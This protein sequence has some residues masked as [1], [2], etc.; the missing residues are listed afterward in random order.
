MP[1]GERTSRP[2]NPD[3]AITA[4]R[5]SRRSGGSSAVIAANLRLPTRPLG[6][7][8]ATVLLVCAAWCGSALS[9]PPAT[10]QIITEDLPLT[11]ETISEMDL[12]LR[13]RFTR[14]WRQEDGTLTLLFNG[15]FGLDM[16]RRQLSAD[17]AVVW[18]QPRRSDPDGRKYYEL[19]IYLSERAK[20]VEAS[21]TVVEDDVLLVSNIRTFG[22][23]I[24]LDDANSPE[25][26]ENSSLYQRAVLD[27][28]R[29]QAGQEPLPALPPV[30][31]PY[32]APL[33][34]R[35]EAARPVRYSLPGIETAATPDGER[36]YVSVGRVYFS[37]SGG[38]DAPLLEIQADAAVVFPK[39]PTSQ[40]AG[41]AEDAGAAT[42][43]PAAAGAASPSAERTR[44]ERGGFTTGIDQDLRGVYLEGDVVLSF[45]NRFVRAERLYYDFEADRALILDA[46]MRVEIPERNIP[47]Y[48]RAAEIRQLSAREYSGQK[49]RLTTSEFYSPHYHIGAEK[50]I[51]RDTTLRDAAGGAA[52]PVTGEY[53]LRD[54]TFNVQGLPLAYWPYLKGRYEQTE[55]MLRSFRT[56]YSD[57]RGVYVETVFKLFEALG[58]APP[59]GWDGTL[60]LDYYS[61]RGPAIG[62]D[63]DYETENYFGLLRTYYVHDQGEDNLGPYRDN[64]PSTEHRGRVLWRHRHY[65]PNDWEITLETAFV[66]DPGFLE[67]WERSEYF[68]GKDQETAVYLKRARDTEAITLLANWRTL[69]FETQTE[70][71]PDLTYRRIGDILGPV[72]SY[73][74]ARVGTVR[75]RPDDRRFIDDGRRDNTNPTDVTFRTGGRQEF[76]LPLKL[77]AFNV[78]PF[79]TA[80]GD[81]WDGEPLDA[82]TKWRGMGTYGLRSASTWA[83]VYDS[84]Q[85]DILDINRIRHIIKPELLAW[86]SHSNT[87]P[88]LLT[89]FDEGIETVADFY[90]A[91][92]ALKQT[93]QT[94]RGAPG[95]RRTVD[96]LTLNLELGLFGEQQAGELSNGYANFIRPEDGRSRNYAAGEMIYRLSDTTSVLYDFNLD[97]NDRDLDRHNISVAVERLPRLAYIFGFRQAD[98][99]DMSLVGGGFNYRISEKHILTSR[100]WWDLKEGELGEIALGYVR[101]LPRWYVGINIEVDRVFEDFKLTFSLWPEGVP[102]WTLGSRR[103]TGLDTSTGIRPK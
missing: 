33:P 12:E 70:H 86:L 32:R 63:L 27:R 100:A 93:W 91:L 9:V 56:G 34:E 71:L 35:P 79:A 99:A 38:P 76:E 45:G 4:R 43:Q 80:R 74:E 87:R 46:V 22:R 75:Y 24:K 53:E 41:A 25:A 3:L 61:E 77:G 52:A 97:L 17:N 94:Q 44:D 92:L 68:E 23:I 65:L 48:L 81:Y 31:A 18:I 72:V 60:K 29:V 21:G 39:Q 28:E 19:T 8:L 101:K 103:F 26:I 88:E 30:A 55:T 42:T 14:Q 69:E 1:N 82:S 50:I 66:S 96:L 57:D 58:V 47:L 2:A 5:R 6:S 67:E 62:I 84:I 40:P 13:G 10:A 15:G 54:A 83:R 51:L 95:N 11:P 20:I 73:S 98:A 36:V 89:P 7:T 16:G 85:S 102:E 78:V 64:T 59:P 37:Q 49:A 90:G